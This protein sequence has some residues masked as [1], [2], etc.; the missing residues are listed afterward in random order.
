M[1]RLLCLVLV[2]LLATCSSALALNYTMTLDNE[3]TF[4]TLEEARVN[5]PAF[6]NERAGRESYG[7]DPCMDG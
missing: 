5:G 6:F 1:K 4:E 3:A 2:L 7:P